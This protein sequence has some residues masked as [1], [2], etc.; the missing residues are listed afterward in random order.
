[1]K[2]LKKYLPDLVAVVLFAVI[3]FVYFMPADIDGR[4]LYRHDTSAGRG[5]GVEQEQYLEKTGDRK[6]TR[7]NS[8]H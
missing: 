4:I 5:A 3:S 1:M 6:S 2:S 7:L 8:S